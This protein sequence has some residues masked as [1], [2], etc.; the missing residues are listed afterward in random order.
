MSEGLR[1][2][3]RV[4][5]AAPVEVVLVDRRHARDCAVW[6]V[7]PPHGCTC[8]RAGGAGVRGERIPD[9]EDQGPPTPE[10]EGRAGEGGNGTLHRRCEVAG[11]P[12][13][14]IPGGIWCERHTS[15]PPAPR[16]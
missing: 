7:E 15:A 16:R 14:A 11:C 3:G 8:G 9:G 12:E 6:R 4:A 1:D 2:V 5:K 10:E 13:F